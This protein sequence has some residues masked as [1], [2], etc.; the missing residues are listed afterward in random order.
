ML[1]SEARREIVG[2]EEGSGGAKY[3]YCQQCGTGDGEGKCRGE[4]DEGEVESDGEGMEDLANEELRELVTTEL[5]GRE[6]KR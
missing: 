2:E 6:A 4:W 5:M 3:V 1:T